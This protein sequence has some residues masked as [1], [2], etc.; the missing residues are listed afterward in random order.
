M[1]DYLNGADIIIIEKSVNVN[2]LDTF[3]NHPHPFHGKCLPPNR[4]LVPKRLGTAGLKNTAHT[5]HNVIC[6]P[7]VGGRNDMNTLPN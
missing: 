7:R 5:A 2:A 4:S 6:V 1:P 3:Q